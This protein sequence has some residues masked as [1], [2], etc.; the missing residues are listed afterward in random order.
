MT[1]NVIPRLGRNRTGAFYLLPILLIVVAC[2][3]QAPLLV[4]E[5]PAISDDSLLTLV[6]YYA[7]S[8]SP[9]GLRWP[10]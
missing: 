1:R 9:A 4:E 7:E 6:E 3:K 5:K 8:A 2:Y 10:K